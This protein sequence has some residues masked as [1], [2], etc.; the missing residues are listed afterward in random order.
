M[1]IVVER[2][3]STQQ[4]VSFRWS[5]RSNSAEQGTDF[6]GIGPDTEQIPAGARDGNADDSA[7]VRCDRREH[8]GVPGRDRARPVG[9]HARR[10]L[11]RGRDR[12]RRRLTERPVLGRRHSLPRDCGRAGAAADRARYLA[13]SVPAARSPLPRQRAAGGARDVA[14]RERSDRHLAVDSALEVEALAKTL[15]SKEGIEHGFETAQGS[16]VVTFEVDLRDSGA[17]G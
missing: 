1:R 17:S 4:P 5:L 9:R 12:R 14:A 11:A 2:H 13:R 10:A 7:R 15:P 3:G 8:R 16:V 6:A